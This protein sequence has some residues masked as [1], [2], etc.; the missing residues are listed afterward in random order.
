MTGSTSAQQEELRGPRI[1]V[2]RTYRG[3]YRRMHIWMGMIQTVAAAAMG[4]L[5]FLI[6]LILRRTGDDLSFIR[7]RWDVILAMC[8]ACFAMSQIISYII[9]INVF[10]PLR[11][12]SDASLKVAEGDYTVRLENTAVLDEL[13][14]TIDNFNLMVRE[15]S[16]IELMRKDFVANAS[17]EFKTPITAISNY[18]EFLQ[19]PDL[20]EEERREYLDR[21]IKHSKRL[22][23]LVENTLRLSKIESQQMEYPSVTYRLDEQI[24]E[25]IL[26]LESQWEEKNIPLDIDLPD[27]EFTGH[28]DILYYVWTNIVGNAVKYSPDGSPISVSLR[29]QADCVQV[30]VAD[31]GIGMDEET[32]A[33]IFDMFYQGDTSKRDEGNGLGLTLCKT[34]VDYCSG[35]IDVESYPGR[36]SIFTVTLPKGR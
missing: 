29:E 18:A 11:E 20:S 31:S 34:I 26:S 3:S 2:R 36:G 1:P 15:L 25:A 7:Q 4:I 22:N 13:H 33:H 8:L 32:R 6:I 28:K 17:H 16:S 10:D 19:D 27:C 9:T 30:T 14:Q 12:L 35:A 24:R 5:S 23:Q 21:I